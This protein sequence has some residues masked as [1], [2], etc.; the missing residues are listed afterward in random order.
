VKQKVFR[1]S[2]KKYLIMMFFLYALYALVFYYSYLIYRK[3]PSFDPFKMPYFY[4]MI[5]SALVLLLSSLSIIAF[6]LNKCLIVTPQFLEYKHGGSSFAVT[7]KDLVFKP[8]SREGGLYRSAMISDGRRFGSFDT[9]F[10]K[11]FDLMVK[12]LEVALESKSTKLM[13]L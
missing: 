5:A 13:D 4:G 3:I 9:L 10:F 12:V 1:A 6:N 11:D 8:P 2:L 7:W